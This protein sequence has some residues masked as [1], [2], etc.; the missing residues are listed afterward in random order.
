MGIGTSD[1]DRSRKLAYLETFEGFTQVKKYG[2]IAVFF[3]FC[4]QSEMVHSFFL[5][6]RSSGWRYRLIRSPQPVT[7]E[8]FGFVLFA[9]IVE[10]I[11]STLSSVI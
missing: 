8:G 7:I 6:K 10:A 5:A 11:Y 2:S 9:V 3:F 4:L 1:D